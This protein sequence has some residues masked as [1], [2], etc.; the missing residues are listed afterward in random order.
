M[1]PVA[2]HIV[3]SE[4]DRTRR[5]VRLGLRVGES[6]AIGSIRVQSL[7]TAAGCGEGTAPAALGCDLP[8]SSIHFASRLQELH[9]CA[10]IDLG[11][12]SYT[13]IVSGSHLQI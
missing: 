10:V 12:R 4:G 8:V 3:D 1:V 13:I 2:V 5:T 9:F 6:Q 11:L 7:G